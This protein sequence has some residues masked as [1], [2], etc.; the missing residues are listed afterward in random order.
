VS[1]GGIPIDGGKGIIGGYMPGYTPRNPLMF[2]YYGII[3]Y[4]LNAGY[5]R[6][7]GVRRF[8]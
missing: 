8:L 2:G 4:P 3:Y 6:G 5:W 1:C 7:G